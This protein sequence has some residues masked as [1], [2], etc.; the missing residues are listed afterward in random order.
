GVRDGRGDLP[1]VPPR[2]TPALARLGLLRGRRRDRRPRAVVRT[3][4][5]GGAVGLPGGDARAVAAGTG[6]RRSGPLADRACARVLR[7]R[8]ARPVAARGP[9]RRDRVRTLRTLVAHPGDAPLA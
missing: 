7:A 5:R 3:D 2:E 9:L 4:P 6:R 8:R 1:G